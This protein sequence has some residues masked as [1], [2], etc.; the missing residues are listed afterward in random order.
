[1]RIV[2]SFQ[3]IISR[4]DLDLLKI[5]L[6]HLKIFVVC[7]IKVCYGKTDKFIVNS[8]NIVVFLNYFCL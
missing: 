6:D 2:Y 4:N 7:S 8:F 5:T 1:M 3:L